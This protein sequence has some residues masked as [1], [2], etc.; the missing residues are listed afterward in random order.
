VVH[1]TYDHPDNERSPSPPL[2]IPPALAPPR[3][4]MVG[5]HTI[6]VATVN[7]SICLIHTSHT[8]PAGLLEAMQSVLVKA[9]Q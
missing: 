7:G 8:L 9:C 1:L 4:S 2:R 6:G 5:E 3:P